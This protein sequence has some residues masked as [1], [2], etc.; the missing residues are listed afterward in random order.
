MET[1]TVL[2]IKELRDKIREQLAS[3]DTSQFSNDKFGSE[4][5]Y[6][7][8]GI[9]LGLESILTDVTYLVKAHNIYSDFDPGREKYHN[10]KSYEYFI[11]FGI[12]TD[13]C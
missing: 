8:K 4:S 13:T 1:P 7:G 2:K 10:L 11:L 5:E 3:I 6:S 9:Y 12:T